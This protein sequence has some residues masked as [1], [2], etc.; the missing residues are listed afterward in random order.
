MVAGMKTYPGEVS[1]LRDKGITGKPQS[2]F[3]IATTAQHWRGGV[4]CRNGI[5]WTIADVV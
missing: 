5:L 2:D 4:V 1:P 3:K